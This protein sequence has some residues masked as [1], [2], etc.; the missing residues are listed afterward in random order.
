MLSFYKTKDSK[1]LF[2][3][4]KKKKQKKT[5]KKKKKKKKK[6]TIII[7]MDPISEFARSVWRGHQV[8]LMSMGSVLFFRRFS[9]NYV[10]H[11]RCR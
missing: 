5:K 8:E 1:S 7:G 10:N 11:G 3:A 4:K 6:K 2:L 9:F